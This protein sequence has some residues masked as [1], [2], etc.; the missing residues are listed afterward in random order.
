MQNLSHHVEKRLVLDQRN[1]NATQMI[2]KEAFVAVR[3][4]L[5]RFKGDVLC[6]QLM[7]SAPHQE[8]L[9]TDQVSKPRKLFLA[10]GAHHI[11]AQPHFAVTAAADAPQQFVIRDLS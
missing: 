11:P 7:K 1:Q 8:R 5:E 9:S 10:L 6:R 2:A 3:L 4:R